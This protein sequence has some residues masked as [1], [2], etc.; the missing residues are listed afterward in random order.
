M[1]DISV[2][3]VTSESEASMEKV[4]NEIIL[5]LNPYDPG[6]QQLVKLMNLIIDNEFDSDELKIL[7]EEFIY[8]MQCLLKY[9][10][11]RAKSEAKNNTDDL[12]KFLNRDILMEYSKEKKW[13]TK[14]Y[15]EICEKLGN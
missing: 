1:R 6:D 4:K 13:K 14:D 10:W 9:D 11:E 7:K 3:F 12:I 8:S 15:N 2:K 5:R